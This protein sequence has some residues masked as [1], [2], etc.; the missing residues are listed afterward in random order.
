MSRTLPR[1]MATAFLIAAAPLAA[2]AQH[3]DSKGGTPTDAGF[4]T[5]ASGAGL[6][7]IEAAKLAD[8][9]AGSDKVK[10]FARQIIAD[11]T[12]AGEELKTLAAGDRGYA[13]AEQPPPANQKDINALQMLH[14]AAFDKEFAKVMVADHQKAVAIF[15]VEAEKGSNK[16]LQAFATKTLPTLKEHLKMARALN[17]GK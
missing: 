11:H 13:T 8:T 1:L 2:F 3:T 10:T 5:N 15:E 9:N 12:K 4:V 7:E 16:E 17:G 6:A 14:G